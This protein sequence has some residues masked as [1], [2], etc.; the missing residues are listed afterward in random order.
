MKKWIIVTL[1]IVIVAWVLLSG[2][3][4]KTE[5]QTITSQTSVKTETF[6]E[7]QKTVEVFSS[8]KKDEYT[9]FLETSDESGYEI[10]DASIYTDKYFIYYTVTYRKIK[11]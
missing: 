7:T 11:Q 3:G 2:C 5:A 6:T 4:E 9:Q 1:F 8:I 10:I